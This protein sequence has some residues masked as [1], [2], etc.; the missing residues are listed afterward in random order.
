MEIRG[1]AQTP[2]AS[3]PEVL[4]VPMPPPPPPPLVPGLRRVLVVALAALVALG[5]VASPGWAATPASAAATPARLT[6]LAHLDFLGDRVDPP[7]QAGHT[8]WRLD[9]EPEI[10]VLWTYAEP[11]PTAATG[12]SGAGPTTRRPTPG[13]RGRS[14]PTT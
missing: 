12:A 11:S 10:G 9:Q 6:N 4:E 5:M 1:Y 14:T 8:T 2:A 7:D 13:D 3:R